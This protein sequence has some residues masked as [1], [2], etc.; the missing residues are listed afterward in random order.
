MQMRRGQKP[1]TYVDLPIYEM[2]T[3]SLVIFE[4]H[5]QHFFIVD[6]ISEM[7]NTTAMLRMAGTDKKFT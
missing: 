2:C 1:G 6:C 4:V 3:E 5:K 7:Y